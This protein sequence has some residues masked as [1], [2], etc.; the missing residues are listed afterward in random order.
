MVIKSQTGLQVVEK[1]FSFTSYLALSNL[2]TNKVFQP[3]SMLLTQT[4]QIT[5]KKRT[6]EFRERVERE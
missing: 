6:S 3:S 4:P 1:L 5:R 2:H